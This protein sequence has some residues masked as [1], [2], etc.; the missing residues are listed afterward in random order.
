[1]NNLENHP[2]NGMRSPVGTSQKETSRTVPRT[3]EIAM[4]CKGDD[5]YGVAAVLK[6]YA[7]CLPDIQF[8]CLGQ[9]SMFDWLTQNGNHVHLMDGLASFTATSSVS[10]LIR[11]PL[12]LAK[13]RRDAAQLHKLFQRLEIKIVHAHW[14]PQHIIA[15]HMRRMGYSAVW[16]IHNNMS[17]RRMFGLGVKLNHCLA[18][19]GA[20]LLIPVSNF[21]GSNW[22]G[23][24]VPIQTIHNVANVIFKEPN[25]T[26]TNPIRCVIAGRLTEDKGHHLALQAVLSARAAGYDVRLD[27][28][29]GP[30]VNNSYFDQ[31]KTLAEQSGQQEC[32]RFMGFCTDLRRH[33]QSYSL[34]LQCRISPEPCSMWVCETLVDG[35]P[36]IAADSGGTPELVDDR[37]TGILFRSGDV[38]DLT[39]K[40]IKVAADPS[41]LNAMRRQTFSRGQELFRLERFITQTVNAYSTLIPGATAGRGI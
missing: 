23:A 8:V 34:G 37:V 36:L 24:G 7:Q 19:W 40:L 39:A 3:C 27:I 29:G 12:A 18:R 4:L 2:S 35:L 6:L 30:L 28:F 9:G 38:E 25:E 5:R 17:S 26:V 11:L 31:L 14:L 1:M 41:G 13:A 33:H 20:D 21:I 16:H 22:R 32:I 10:T 15:G